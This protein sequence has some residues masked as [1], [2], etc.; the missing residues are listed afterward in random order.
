MLCAW[1]S[2]YALADAHFGQR[3]RACCSILGPAAMRMLLWTQ[4]GKHGQ[5]ALHLGQPLLAC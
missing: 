5:A 4:A 2:G 3:P 1:A